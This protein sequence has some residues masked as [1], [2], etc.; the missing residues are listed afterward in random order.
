[1]KTLTQKNHDIKRSMKFENRKQSEHAERKMKDLNIK[2]IHLDKLL[3]NKERELEDLRNS[4]DN[5]HRK[6]RTDLK[7]SKKVMNTN[8][9]N[10]KILQSFERELKLKDKKI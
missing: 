2:I 6:D 1:M 5:I 4:V 7:I 9:K 3:Q 8:Q 10:M